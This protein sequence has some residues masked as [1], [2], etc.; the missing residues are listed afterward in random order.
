MFVLKNV[1]YKGILKI[2]HLEIPANKVTCIAGES[3]SG[4]TTL[5]RLLNKM[6]SPDEG[7]VYFL[8]NK[9]SELDAV[10]LRRKVVMLSQTPVIFP[11]TVE[12]NLQLGLRFSEKPDADA[13]KLL[14]TLRAVRLVKELTDNA[15]KLSGGEQQ[16]LALARV[17]LLDPDVFLLDEPSSA[18]DEETEQLV[19]EKLVQHTRA[20]GK[21]LVMVTHSKKVAREFADHCIN[22]KDGKILRR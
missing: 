12:E 17:L 8:E 18:L 2:E 11:G 14:E 3:G 21:S 7:E 20:R 10:Q 1:Q 5:L 22:L 9:L 13:G 16:R 19:I 15:E 4:K 6:I